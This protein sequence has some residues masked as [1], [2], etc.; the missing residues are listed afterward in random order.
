MFESENK[1]KGKQFTKKIL[2]CNQNNLT[3]LTKIIDTT[4]F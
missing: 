3:I 2:S 1:K 4:D